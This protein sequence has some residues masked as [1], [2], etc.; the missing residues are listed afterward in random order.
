[1]MLLKGSNFLTEHYSGLIADV[2]CDND[3]STK[4]NTGLLDIL[5]DAD[6]IV[7]AGEALSHCLANTVQDIAKEFGDDNIKKF[8][9]LTDCSSSVSGFEKLGKDFVINMSK[10]GMKLTTTRD[11]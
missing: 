2:P 5:S 8:T 1:M 6:E 10:R 7:L 11:W 4:L 9:L 3:P